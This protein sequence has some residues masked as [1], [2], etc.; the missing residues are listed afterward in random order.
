M[1]PKARYFHNNKISSISDYTDR[2]WMKR[3]ELFQMYEQSSNGFYVPDENVW[4]QKYLHF[5]KSRILGQI[6]NQKPRIVTEELTLL[7]SIARQQVGWTI[8]SAFHFHITVINNFTVSNRVSNW[9]VIVSLLSRFRAAVFVQCGLL[10]EDEGNAE[11]S[12]MRWIR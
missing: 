7:L 10:T 4:A 5:D 12:V 1:T 2:Y 8:W 11:C 6:Q 3:S 9:G